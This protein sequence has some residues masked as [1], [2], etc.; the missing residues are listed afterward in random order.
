MTL[1]PIVSCDVL[2]DVLLKF[3][4]FPTSTALTKDE[5]VGTEELTE[6][7]STDG[8]HC[9]GLQIDEDGSGDIFVA[10]SLNPVSGVPCCSGGVDI[11][12]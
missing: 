8:V 9:A 5:V 6:R 11:P 3:M 2:F 12:H 7:T 4:T 10:R 1:G